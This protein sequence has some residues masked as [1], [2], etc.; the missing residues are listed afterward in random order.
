MKK[1]SP[2]KTQDNA[3]RYDQELKKPPRENKNVRV[4]NKKL[5]KAAR[6]RS[7]KKPLISKLVDSLRKEKKVFR[8]LIIN[9]EPL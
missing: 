9:S 8:E 5:R 2:T 3:E 7:K 4:D 1:G 6:E